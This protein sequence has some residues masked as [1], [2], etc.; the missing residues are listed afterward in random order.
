M[1]VEINISRE[2]PRRI[3]GWGGLNIYLGRF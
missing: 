3:A 2:R 1:A